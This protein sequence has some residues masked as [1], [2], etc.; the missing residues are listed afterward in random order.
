MKKP[1]VLM[2]VT[3][4]LFEQVFRPETLEKLD[5]F[6]ETIIPAEKGAEWKEFLPT[7]EGIITSWGSLNEMTEEVLDQAPELKII[8]H[9][10]GSARTCAKLA[11]P[12]GIIVTNAA[13]AIAR[14]VAEY[15]L[16]MT[17]ACLRSFP[18]HDKNVK[19][20]RTREELSDGRRH[21]QTRG[22][23]LKKVGLVGFGYTAREFAKLLKIFNADICAFDP[24]VDDEIMEKS[25][26]K[27][28]EDL[29]ELLSNSDVVSLHIPGHARHLIGKEE[30]RCLKDG[31][32][33]INSSGGA[34]Y[35]PEAFTEEVK[36]G[37]FWAATETDPFGSII[38]P[39]SPLRS[40]TNVIIT[41]HIA[42]PTIDARW[43]MGD[44]VVE[45]LRRFFSGEKPLHSITRERVA[46][47]A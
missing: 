47:V 32:I 13:P 36:T 30:F 5:S 22:L 9:A 23:F 28:A 21:I 37:R 24:Y 31:A 41:P 10:A 33:F 25:G 19:E 18:Q 14:S 12:R 35:D 11:I 16:G 45:E 26:V 20:S 2:L 27:R 3:G 42:G 8:G 43:M 17:I 15:C 39:D 38:P 34:V 7:A 44:L 4:S 1:E 46:Y 40:L 6:A 29:K